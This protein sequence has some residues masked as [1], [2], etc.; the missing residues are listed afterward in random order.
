MKLTRLI[1]KAA[2][3]AL[4]VSS[5]AFAQD[6]AKL[7]AAMKT[8]GGNIRPLS[9][10]IKEKNKEQTISAAKKIDA[11]FADAGTFWAARKTEDAIKVNGEARAAAK[12]IIEAAEKGEDAGPVFAK[13]GGTCKACHEAHREEVSKGEYKVK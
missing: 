5:V 9:M 11:A 4:A 8:I 2:L 3:F 12:A 1:S 7:E 13:L 10:A 6:D